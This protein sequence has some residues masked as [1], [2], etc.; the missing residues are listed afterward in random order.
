M[1]AAL[2][3]ACYAPRASRNTLEDIVEAHL[4]E[5]EQIYDERFRNNY[6]PL[7]ARVIHLFKRFQRCGD[8]HFGFLRLRCE[9]CAHERLVPFSC[10]AR[11]L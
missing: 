7:H 6:G 5:L 10:K 8:L 1:E 2:G 11:G 3:Q 9:D 4:E